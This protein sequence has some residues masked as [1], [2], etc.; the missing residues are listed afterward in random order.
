MTHSVANFALVVGL[1]TMLAGCAEESPRLYVNP[2]NA[3]IDAN[4]VL[5]QA[6]DDPDP[7]TRSHAIEAMAQTLGR[8]PG[9]VYKQALG[10]QYPAVRFAAAMAIGDVLYQPATKML[11]SM[12]ADRTESDQAEPDKRVL[13]AVIYAL[14]SLGDTTYTGQL[15]SLV[16]DSEKEV[17]ANA[18]MVLGKMGEKSAIYPLKAQLD[19]EQDLSVKLQIVESLA[20][21]GDR[22]NAFKLE[23]HTKGAYLE[24]R[25]VAIGA[26][27]R[28]RSPRAIPTLMGLLDSRQPPRVRVAAAS[29]LA[30]MGQVQ[31]ESVRMAMRAAEFPQRVLRDARKDGREISEIEVRSLQR[32][33]VIA[34]GWMGKQDAAVIL[35][36][37][38]KSQDG[39]VR[40]AAAMSLVR[41]LKGYRPTGLPAI[42]PKA[43][44]APRAA[45]RPAQPPAPTRQLHTA[46]GKD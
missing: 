11:A 33:A 20:M 39:G 40:V 30:R 6:A 34:L 27:E 41:L 46:G 8:Q 42:P 7:V 37:S 25:L 1:A 10:D 24:D 12:A 16:S 32:L 45:T 19:N 26:M 2:Q 35:H 9:A 28:A 29:A 44:P 17:R 31:P 14:H 23:A 13:C 38:L 43:A 22:Q 4:T 3:Y 21:L 36:S 5:R 18:A 15:G